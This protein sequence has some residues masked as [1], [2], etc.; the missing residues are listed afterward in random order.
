MLFAQGRDLLGQRPDETEA[1]CRRAGNEVIV[2][3]VRHSIYDYVLPV[4]ALKIPFLP[5][6]INLIVGPNDLNNP[7][8]HSLINEKRARF[9]PKLGSWGTSCKLGDVV[10]EELGDVVEN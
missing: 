2:P 7:P 1:V 8:V 10:V 5:S 3:T 4:H 6:D 9:I